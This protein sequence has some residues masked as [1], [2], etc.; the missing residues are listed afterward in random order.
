MHIKGVGTEAG[1]AP[2]REAHNLY[3][4]IAADT[5]LLGLA[6]FLGLSAP[7]SCRC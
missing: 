3:L 7:S 4:G 2:T 6:A 1:Q 5:G